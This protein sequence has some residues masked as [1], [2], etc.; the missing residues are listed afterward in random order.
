LLLVWIGMWVVFDEDKFLV[1][2]GVLYGFL[3]ALAIQ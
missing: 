1:F 3:I 2:W